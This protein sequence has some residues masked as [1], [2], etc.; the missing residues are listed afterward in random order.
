MVEYPS[1]PRLRPSQVTTSSGNSI[2]RYDWH[3]PAASAQLGAGAGG[4]PCPCCGQPEQ[5]LA[6]GPQGLCRVRPCA[7]LGGCRCTMEMLSETGGLDCH[8]ASARRTAVE[9][10]G[11]EKPEATQEILPECLHF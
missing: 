6:G 7:P 5:Q 2:S 10:K 8:M 9:S 4:E 11:K 3:S 1:F